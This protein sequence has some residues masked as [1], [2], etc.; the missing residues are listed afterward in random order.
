MSIYVSEV[1]VGE[2]GKILVKKKCFSL[3]SWPKKLT[4]KKQVHC[5]GERFSKMARFCKRVL[6]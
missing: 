1:E 2:K 4:S 3:A 6:A 5:N